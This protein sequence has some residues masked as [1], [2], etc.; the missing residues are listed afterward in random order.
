MAQQADILAKKDYVDENYQPKLVPGTGININPITNEITATGAGGSTVNYSGTYA[1]GESIGTLTIDGT[2]NLIKIPSLVQGTNITITT[3][4]QTGAKTIAAASG[5]STTLSGLTDVAVASATNNQV[6]KYNSATQTWVNAN[7]SGGGATDLDDLT[8]VEIT[9]PTNGDVLVYNSTTSKWENG[10]SSSGTTVIANPSG[11][12]TDTLNKV[13]IGQD[14]YSIPSGGGGGGSF[15][16]EVIF[17]NEGSSAPSTITLNESMS[18]YDA[19]VLSGYRSGSSYWSSNL[20]L[21]SELTTGKLIALVDDSYY[22]WY[23]IT[24][25]TTLTN[26]GANIVIDKIYGLKFGSGGGSG[27]GGT[28]FTKL[29]QYSGSGTGYASGEIITLSESMDNFDV[30]MFECQWSTAGTGFQSGSVTVETFKKYTTNFYAEYNPAAY[31]DIKYLSDTEI[32]VL[33]SGGA[34]VYAVYGIKY[35]SGS[36][37]GSNVEPN[38]SGTPTDTLNTIG[39]DGTIYDIAGSGGGG[40]KIDTLYEYDGVTQNPATIT[41]DNPTTDYDLILFQTKSGT[42]AVMSMIYDV[43]CLTVGDTIGAG[44]YNGIFVWYYY[45]DVSTLTFRVAA[46]NGY[47]SHVKGIKLGSGGSGAYSESILYDGNG[48]V[49]PATITLSEDYSNFDSLVFC[50]L[51]SADGRMYKYSYQYVISD[52][53]INDNI[54]LVTYSEWASYNITDSTTLTLVNSNGMYIDKIIGIK[55]QGNGGISPTPTEEEI[56][57]FDGSWKNQD[58]I[59]ITP[60]L[61]TITNNELVCSGTH[62]G[63]VVSSVSGIPSDYASYQLIVEGY[64]QG[65]GLQAGRCNPTNDLNAIIGQGTNRISYTNDSVS[66]GNFKFHLKTNSSSEGV[67]LGGYYNVST[68]NYTITKIAFAKNASEREYN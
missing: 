62:C 40:S 49:A 25:D 8:D 14:I 29:A 63:I 50:L 48:S 16:T 10:E 67:F 58:K 28:V 30:L 32:S 18:D 45:T 3:D 60:Y 13:Q 56:I 22:A 27:G 42:N 5:G 65:F 17:Q 35:G 59:T 46:G 38:P 4:P 2:G 36:G 26:A 9:S 66:T 15:E 7:E 11:T 39:I 52:L 54:Q 33:R 51:R 43:N 37:G 61:A 53:S 47:I 68:T 24:D 44:W 41:L 12:A 64:S 20:Y 31:T 55:Y 34:Y 19:I 21:T 6:L 23:T 1:N 57:L